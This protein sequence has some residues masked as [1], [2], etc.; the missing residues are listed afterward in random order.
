MAKIETLTAQQELASNFRD[1]L[2]DSLW[3]SLRDSLWDNLEDELHKS[4]DE[5]QP[6]ETDYMV[7]GTP[8]VDA[9]AIEYANGIRIMKDGTYG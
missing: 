5:I 4:S 9:P 1:S 6:S 2:R 7:D 8:I 3:D